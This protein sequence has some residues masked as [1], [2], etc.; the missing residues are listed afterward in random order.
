MSVAIQP[1]ST[2]L[3]IQP[4]TPRPLFKPLIGGVVYGNRQQYE[5]ASTPGEFLLNAF[6]SRQ[7]GPQSPITLILNWK[8]KP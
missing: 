6:V 8:A 4:G 1:T 7:P 5:V 2:E 3:E